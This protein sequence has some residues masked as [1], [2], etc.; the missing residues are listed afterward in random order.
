MKTLKKYDY[1]FKLMA[2]YL[3]VSFIFYSCVCKT[4]QQQE[5]IVPSKTEKPLYKANGFQNAFDVP[6]RAVIVNQKGMEYLIYYFHGVTIINL[7]KDSLEVVT[8]KN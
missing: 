6:D 1:L 4:K 8:I 3:G 7:T 5:V 2:F